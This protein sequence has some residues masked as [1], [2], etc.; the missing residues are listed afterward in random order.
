[1]Y[2]T[3]QK[4]LKIQLSKP[5]HCTVLCCI[6]LKFKRLLKKKSCYVV[7]LVPIVL[8]SLISVCNENVLPLKFQSPASYALMKLDKPPQA[9]HLTVSDVSARRSSHYDCRVF[10]YFNINA[11]QPSALLRYDIL[12]CIIRSK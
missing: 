11:L 7:F 12:V 1:M 6:V 4:R 3:L 2:T 10:S 5:L 8:L 9:S